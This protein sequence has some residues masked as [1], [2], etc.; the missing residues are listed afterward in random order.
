MLLS[1]SLRKV[2]NVKLRDLTFLCLLVWAE[3]RLSRL[4]LNTLVTARQE[5]VYVPSFHLLP[6]TSCQKQTFLQP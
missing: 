4:H 3:K 1:T 6:L 5:K 2:L